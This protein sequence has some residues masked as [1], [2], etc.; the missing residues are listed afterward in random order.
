[1]CI[2]Y[3][4]IQR[5]SNFEWLDEVSESRNFVKTLERR[6]VTFIGHLSSHAELI[7]DI[8]K[9]VGKEMSKIVQFVNSVI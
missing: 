8:I 2:K 7:C 6:R 9:A 3:E 1:M 5:K 4:L